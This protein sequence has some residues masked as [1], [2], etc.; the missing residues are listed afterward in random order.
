MSL[1]HTKAWLTLLKIFD[2]SIC[3]IAFMCEITKA[4]FFASYTGILFEFTV[5]AATASLN[6]YS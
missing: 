5:Q 4:F 3:I 1:R 6:I 2:T